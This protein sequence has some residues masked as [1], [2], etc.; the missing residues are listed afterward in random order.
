MMYRPEIEIKE[1]QRRQRLRSFRRI[2]SQWLLLLPVVALACGFRLLGHTDDGFVVATAQI[3]PKH[4]IR[5]IDR[6]RI[7]RD[8]IPPLNLNTLNY[9][10]QFDDL[11]DIQLEAA[12]KN[13]LQ[14]PETI[15]DPS[16]CTQLYRIKDNDFFRID[17]MTFAKPYLIPEAYMLLQYIGERFH[18]LLDENYPDNRHHYRLI[19]TSALR[20]QQD[21][22]RLRLRNRNATENS[23]HRYGTT[24]DISYI[25]FEADRNVDVNELFLKNILA[26]ALY[27]LRYE[28]LCYV[29]YE[30][31]QS[32][33]HITVR[34]TEYKG[35]SPSSVRR[36]ADLAGIHKGEW[37][38]DGTL[39]ATEALSKEYREHGTIHGK[40]VGAPQTKTIKNNRPSH[41]SGRSS[42]KKTNGKSKSANPSSSQDK[43]RNVPAPGQSG[44]EGIIAW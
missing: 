5:S 6:V 24:F 8:Q 12:M 16:A 38:D 22:D 23:C 33:F 17:S 36:Y 35:K 13:G 43:Y 41:S 26:T 19:V 4:S 37:G 9:S 30:R 42:S 18:E 3:A 7:N 28:G 1:I 27:E 10:R 15:A 14:H 11:N 32:C 44:E 31:G 20:S 39:T 21:V 34:N 2:A 25:R 40:P 29:K